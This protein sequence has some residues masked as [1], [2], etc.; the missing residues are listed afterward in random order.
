M[1]AAGSG[2]V[3]DRQGHIV[4]NAHVTRDADL[5]FAIPSNIVKRVVPVLIEQGKFTWPW[6]GVQGTTLR[7][8]IAQANGLAV[9]RGAYIIDVATDGPARAA[10]LR[11]STGRAMIDGLT[12]PVGGDVITAI[13]GQPIR[14]MEDLIVYISQRQVGDRVVLTV[15][16]GGKSVEI[17]VTLAA[18]PT[19]LRR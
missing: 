16:R 14:S 9:T 10:G 11:G 15:L 3:Y 19:R 7:P 6:L 12:V 5:I 2:F 13:D 17:P 4:T 18:R 8:R 1:G